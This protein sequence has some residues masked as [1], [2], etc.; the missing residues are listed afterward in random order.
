[1]NCT[2]KSEIEEHLVERL[3]EKEPEGHHHAAR[4]AGYGFCI[5][6]NTLESRPYMDVIQSVD[7]P[8]KAGGFK[9]IKPKMC[10]YFSYCPFC[11]KPAADEKPD[12]KIGGV[13]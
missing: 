4:L 6:G 2:C 10:M 12:G 13:E 1:M 3:K 11:G 5:V 8:R 7:V 9:N